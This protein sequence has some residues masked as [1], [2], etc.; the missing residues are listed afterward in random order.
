M[1]LSPGDLISG[2][3]RIVRL[4]GHGGMGSVYE[5]RH[6]LLG[7]AVALKFL[8]LELAKRPGLAARFLQE[9]RVSATIQSAH[10]TRVTDVDTTR[11]GA[12]YL[13]MELLTGQSLQA[14]LD[15]QRRLSKD[16][17]VDF[18]LQILAGL[19]AA[20]ALGVVHRDLKPDN[21]FITT[22]GGGPL[23]K[24][25][26]FGIAKLRESSEYKQGLTGAGMVMGTPEYMAPEQLYAASEVDLRADF[27]SLGIM[28]FEMLSG[29]RPADGESA[30]AIV[31]KVLSNNTRSL[32]E[33]MPDLPEGLVA[34]VH[35]AM[36]ADREQR[37]ANAF[38]MRRAL[39][40]FAGELSH[41]GRLAATSAPVAPGYALA[42]GASEQPPPPDT[43]FGP[44]P[45]SVGEKLPDTVDAPV[46]GIAATLPP[47]ARGRAGGSTQAAAPPVFVPPLAAPA[48]RRP[49]R[50]RGGRTA[51]VLLILTIALGAAALVALRFVFEDRATSGP[52]PFTGMEPSPAAAPS[53][54]EP[55][56]IP[57]PPDTA[58]PMAPRQNPQP[59]G[60]AATPGPAAPVTTGAP[61]PVLTPGADAGTPSTFPLPLPFPSFTLPSSLPPLPTAFPTTL[62]TSFPSVLPPIPGLTPA[63]APLPPPVAPVA[64]PG[65]GQ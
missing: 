32:A 1:T 5:A 40:A 31:S 14:V 65:P 15:K 63:P 53:T 3:Y 64:P 29:A 54:I 17:A 57:T 18:T 33:L 39:S 13:V 43:T 23:L 25:I 44:P 48:V 24:L 21:V 30:E 19:E 8:H 11:D 55:I 20:H 36:S 26:D 35:R 49:R 46:P 37:P 16:Q 38:E 60:P 6:E 2:K 51:L 59:R 42:R 58:P 56:E 62:P 34:I 9:A 28:L 41:A 47:E 12:P 61:N 50:A 7:A 4:I 27:Y 22:S 10:V 45:A 52:T